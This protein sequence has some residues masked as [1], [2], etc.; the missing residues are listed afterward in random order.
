MK[1]V[2]MKFGNTE[3][4]VSVKEEN[5]IGVIEANEVLKGKTEDQIIKEA[6]ENPID[7]ARLREL[8]HEGEKVCVVIPDVTRAWQRTG[9]YLNKVGRRAK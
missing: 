1:K 3:M 2:K 5:L 6:L 7:S 8:V 4:Y 9:I